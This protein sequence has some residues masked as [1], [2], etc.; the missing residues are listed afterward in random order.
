MPRTKLTFYVAT[1]DLRAALTSVI[2]HADKEVA[3]IDIVHFTLTQNNLYVTATNR[4]TA[5]LAVVSAWG[6]DGLTGAINED[7]SF[8]LPPALA[9]EIAALFRG[10]SKADQEDAQSELFITVGS[11]YIEVVD[12]GGLF[13]GKELRE[14]LATDSTAFPLA[15]GRLFSSSLLDRQVLPE[16]VATQG[17]FLTMF[18]TA[19][20]SYGAEL[21]I[22][23]TNVGNRFLIACGES[24]LGLLFGI[25]LDIESDTNPA[26]K[27][28]D[29]HQNWVDRISDFVEGGPAPRDEA[30]EDA[31]P[32]RG[33]ARVTV[34]NL[35]DLEVVR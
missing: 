14:P 5:A 32:G 29:A 19:A 3:G 11:E 25:R 21:V 15:W 7:D 6:I 27:I 16:Q 1:D 34:T 9:A 24:F 13:P 28:R 26:G 12:V 17:K 8:N 20:K 2:P 33:A 30:A 18:A 35:R 4:T 22:R 10:K 23:P 31:A